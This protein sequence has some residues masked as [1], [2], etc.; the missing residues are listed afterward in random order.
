MIGILY[1][2]HPKLWRLEVQTVDVP[3]FL[4]LSF[5]IF[6]IILSSVVAKYNTQ[7]PRQPFPSFP[8]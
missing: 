1:I 8:P 6:E 3:F 5:F 2:S 7:D 4:L